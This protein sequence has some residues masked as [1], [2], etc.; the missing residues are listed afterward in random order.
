MNADVAMNS[1]SASSPAPQ[2]T[3][4]D[5][6]TYSPFPVLVSR[7][8][9]GV[10]IFV[11]DK[12]AAFFETEKQEMMGR[13]ALSFFNNPEDYTGLMGL[14]QKREQ[15]ADFETILT[16]ASK[17][18][19]A[20]FLTA[21]L[22]IRFSEPAV[23]FY[24][25]DAAGCREIDELC[26]RIGRV[27]QSGIYIV[28]DRVIKMV[29]R[30]LTEYM[31]YTAE[32][33]IG[34]ASTDYIHAE[35]KT[36]VR[37]AAIRMLSGRR[38]DPYTYRII[39]KQGHVRWFAET[40][41]S[42]PYMGKK[43]FLGNIVETGGKKEKTEKITKAGYF[44]GLTG[45][46]DKHLF[47]DRLRAAISFAGRYQHKLAVM[48]MNIDRFKDLNDVLGV[49]AGDELLNAVARRLEVL[50]RKE[51]TIARL[52]GDEFIALVPRLD[53]VN[54]IFRVAR[55]VMDAFQLPFIVQ[56]QQIFIHMSLGVSIFPN[57]G[58]DAE[59]L[60]RNSDM[61]MNKAKAL[62]RNQYCLFDTR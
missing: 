8:T 32:E 13:T 29:N 19:V 61:A 10:L 20:V 57:H 52:G 27:F 6:L 40:V 25:A 42:I 26:G 15:I 44:D 56:G 5:L 24:I 45:L 38:Q 47:C 39:D 49:Q 34:T 28:Q 48:M 62:G 46:P 4:F 50:F 53:Q 7:L 37:E 58:K 14:L 9:D 35:D 54:H 2:G 18:R 59:A 30:Y 31:G 36:T 16:T 12:A 51:D 3:C 41:V 43:A 21:G 55:R 22:V 60:I 33:L 1:T 23:V 11:N 17:S